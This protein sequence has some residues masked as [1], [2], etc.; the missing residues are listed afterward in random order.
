MNRRIFILIS[1]AVSF[2][3]GQPL[4]SFEK[5]ITHPTL[6]SKAVGASVLDDYLETQMGLA[7]GLNTQLTFSNT[8]T[9]WKKFF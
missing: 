2:G 1:L 8:G 3:L 9:S 6:T 5:E 7:Q 4:Y